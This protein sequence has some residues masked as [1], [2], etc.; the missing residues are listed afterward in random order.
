MTSNARIDLD[1][2][3]Q[4]DIESYPDSL[5]EFSRT[6]DIKLPGLD[7]GNGKALAAMT[8]HPNLYWITDDCNN[9]C[10]KFNIKSTNPLQFF[11]KKAQIG[12]KSCETRGRNYVLYPYQLSKKKAM[13]AGFVWNGTEEQKNIEIENIK[14][15]IQGNYCDVPNKDWQLGHKNPDSGDNSSSN[16]VLQPPIQAKYRDNYVFLN[17]LTKMPT[18]KKFEKLYNAGKSPYTKEQLIQFRDIFN[19]LPLD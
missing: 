2:V 17:T 9:F 11:N 19:S 8:H 4:D 7:T 1:F 3:I 14:A 13:R 15:H 6:N 5:I 18:P 16:L 10:K 12:L